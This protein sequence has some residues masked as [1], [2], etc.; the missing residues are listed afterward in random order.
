M[1]VF[2]DDIWEESGALT[3]VPGSHKLHYEVPGNP[4][5]ESPSTEDINVDG[6]VPAEL[7]AGSVLFRVPEV[8]HAV[9]PIHHLRRYVTASYSIRGRVSGLMEQKIAET[10]KERRESE[11]PV[12]E[13]VREYWDY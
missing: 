10:M 3:Y 13:D 5:Y 1:A 4:G 9:N 12:P 8:W 2:L 11:E 7:K 6:Y